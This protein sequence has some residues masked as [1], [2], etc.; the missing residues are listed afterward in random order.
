MQRWIKYTAP[1]ESINQSSGASVYEPYLIF[2]VFCPLT[3]LTFFYFSSSFAFLSPLTYLVSIYRLFP[4]HFI[5]FSP[6][7]LSSLP[8]LSFALS[9]LLS[10]PPTH[11]FLTHLSP[12]SLLLLLLLLPLLHFRY[13]SRSCILSLLTLFSFSPTHSFS[14]SCRLFL[15][16]YGARCVYL[17]T[18]CHC[19]PQR[20]ANPLLS[21]RGA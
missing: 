9:G 18:G 10:L 16:Q 6:S 19:L 15:C 20:Y 17:H 7:F 1:N 21:L 8:S 2:S 14:L 11:P 12:Y 5:V 4:H 3:L 13:L